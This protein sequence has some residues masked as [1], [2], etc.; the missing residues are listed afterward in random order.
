MLLFEYTN[1][2]T[3][4][5]S[6]ATGSQNQATEE[7]FIVQNTSMSVPATVTHH[8][9]PLHQIV[10]ALPLREDGKI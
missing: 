4:M 9:Q 7:V 3:P 2:Q 6:T 10:W 5:N 8:G 1:A